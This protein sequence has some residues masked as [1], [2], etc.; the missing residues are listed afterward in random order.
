MTVQRIL[1][2]IQRVE[3]T[4]IAPDAT[5]SDA[6]ELLATRNVGAALVSSDGAKVEGIIS[7]RDIVRGLNETGGSMLDHP[8]SELMTEKVVTCVATDSASGIMAVMIK[9]HLRHMPVVDGDHFVG[10]LSIR[11][12]LQLRLSEVQSEADAMRSYI[13]GNT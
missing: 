1:D 12:L 10:M 9:K 2:S 6:L 11:D 5:I 4:Y 8:V 13:A 3:R 7:E